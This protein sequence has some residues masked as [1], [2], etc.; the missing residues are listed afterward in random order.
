MLSVIKRRNA[1]PAGWD[2]F[3]NGRDFDRLFGT[4]FGAP[5]LSGW[6]PAVDVRETEN[7]F[8]ISAELPGLTADDVEITVE[9][10]V[11][12]LGGEKKAEYEEGRRATWR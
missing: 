5:S 10:G 3:D 1:S 9:N 8:L 12:S 6:S 2:F 11:L 4:A 7:E